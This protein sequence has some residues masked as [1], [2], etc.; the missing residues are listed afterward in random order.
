MTLL[1]GAPEDAGEA[2]LLTIVYWV[3]SLKNTKIQVN[4]DGCRGNWVSFSVS[5]LCYNL[6]SA[7]QIV[8]KKKLKRYSF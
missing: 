1:C 2:R 8:T 3:R 6:S 4:T 7:S 5:F